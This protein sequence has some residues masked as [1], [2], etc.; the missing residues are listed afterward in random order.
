VTLRDGHVGN[1]SVLDGRVANVRVANPE[2]HAD[3]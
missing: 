2:A 1:G 3:A